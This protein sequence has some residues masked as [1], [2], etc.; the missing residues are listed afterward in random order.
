MTTVATMDHVLILVAALA[1][2]ASAVWVMVDVV[3]TS[4]LSLYYRIA[5][6]FVAVFLPVVGAVLWLVVR[7]V[8]SAS[9]GT[10]AR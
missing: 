8:G 4:G 2:F 5:W 1:C 7:S 10:A 3:R 9:G 6:S